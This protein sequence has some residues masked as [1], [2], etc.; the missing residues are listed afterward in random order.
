MRVGES[1]RDPR[2]T[3]SPSAFPTRAKEVAAVHRER[4]RASVP[5]AA[6][7]RRT[8]SR[9]R[10]ARA[11]RCCGGPGAGRHAASRRGRR[12]ASRGGSGPATPC[13]R[14]TRRAR[15]G[16]ARSRIAPPRD[17]SYGPRDLRSPP[18]EAGDLRSRLVMRHVRLLPKK[19][20]I[21]LGI[22]DRLLRM[23]ARRSDGSR[24]SSPRTTRRGTPPSRP[25]RGEGRGAPIAGRRP[26]F[27]ESRLL[28]VRPGT[29]PPCP[30]ACRPARSVA[31]M[32]TSPP[33]AGRGRLRER[34]PA[35]LPPSLSSRR[36]R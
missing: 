15:R 32:M 16:G 17:A 25:R 27:L 6:A 36:N 26:V 4:R 8:S 9:R 33:R 34:S 1:R 13:A 5:S 24:R 31:I 12:A 28:D 21:V 35:P 23:R 22:V 14:R 7:Q 30:P 20:S 29:R 3:P 19:V 2:A 18:L 10:G 11:P